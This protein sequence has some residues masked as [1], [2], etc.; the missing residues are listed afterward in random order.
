MSAASVVA[1]GRVAAA[2]LMVDTC[3]IRRVTGRPVNPITLK[4]AP[5]YETIYTGVCRVQ[6]R[7]TAAGQPEAGDHSSTT[8]RTIVSVPMSVTDV[9]VDD[10]VVVASSGDADL[11]DRVLRVRSLFHKTHA[12]ARRLE[13]EEVQA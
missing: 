11:V 12:T 9:R 2:A 6:L 5:T 1:R 4:I 8:V 3:T 10:E 7:D 13:C